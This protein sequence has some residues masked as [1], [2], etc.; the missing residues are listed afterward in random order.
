MILFEK[1]QV[2]GEKSTVSLGLTR[3][4]EYFKIN[5][6]HN[7]SKFDKQLL[8]GQLPYE[9]NRIHQVR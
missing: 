9:V 2:V 1:G 4:K 6:I 5:L 8:M 7:I 3:T